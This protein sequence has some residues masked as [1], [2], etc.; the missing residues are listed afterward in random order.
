MA[1]TTTANSGHGY[2]WSYYA[3]QVKE[4]PLSTRSNMVLGAGIRVRILFPTSRG[5]GHRW[6][7]SHPLGGDLNV[8]AREALRSGLVHPHDADAWWAAFVD[9]EGGGHEES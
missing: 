5:P 4:V 7:N 3:D 8:G 1:A 6:F 9:V 2:R